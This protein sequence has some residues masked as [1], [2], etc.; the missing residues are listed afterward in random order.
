MAVLNAPIVLGPNQP[1]HFYRGGAGIASLR[2]I[3]QPSAN[4]PQ[5]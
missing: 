1:A 4:S 5:D 3:P 2:G